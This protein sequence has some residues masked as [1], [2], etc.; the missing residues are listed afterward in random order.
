MK[1]FI[2]AL[3]TLLCA[4][5]L[6]SAVPDSVVTGPY[7]ISFD[8]G[9]T[10]SDYNVTV[11]PPVMDET[12]GG[13]KRTDYSVRIA[14]RTGLGRGASISVRTIENG[15]AGVLTGS[16]IAQALSLQYTN[17]PRYSNIQTAARTIDGV[18]GAV[19]SVNYATDSRTVITG[20][21]AMYP[22]AFDRSSIVD[23]YSLYP[24]NEGTL[25]LLKTIHIEKIAS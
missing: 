7:K 10:R 6:V 16:D 24:W 18:S 23:I 14:N 17:D 20:Y 5:I 19:L 22:L 3:I 11:A 1:M 13:D 2:L 9:L 21:E 25:Q 4:P 8:I 15:N 12:L